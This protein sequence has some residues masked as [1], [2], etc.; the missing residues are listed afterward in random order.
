MSWSRQIGEDIRAGKLRRVS[1]VIEDP[2]NSGQVAALFD[3]MLY[4]QRMGR[5]L[6]VVN[7][8]REPDG[9]ERLV[10]IS[11]PPHFTDAL[12]AVAWTYHDPTHPLG[13]PPWLYATLARR[14]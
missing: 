2:G 3:R 4:G 11:V 14:T 9:S 12:E 7:G 8:T 5:V 10:A 13:C 6:V 1:E